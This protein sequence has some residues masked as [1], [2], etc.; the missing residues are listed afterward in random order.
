MPS[1]TKRPRKTPSKTPKNMG[2]P[3]LT[4]AHQSNVVRD[5]PDGEESLFEIVKSGKMALTVMN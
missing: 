3:S 4:P 1:M 5:V 2:P